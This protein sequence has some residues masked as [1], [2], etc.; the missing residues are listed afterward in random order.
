M[1]WKVDW[2]TL[3]K[4][5]ENFLDELDWLFVQENLEDAHIVPKSVA[6]I[7]ATNKNT[8]QIFSSYL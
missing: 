3:V 8:N 7:L 5:E 1:H 2:K 6:G 4:T